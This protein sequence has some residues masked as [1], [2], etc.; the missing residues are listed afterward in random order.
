MLKKAC[1]PHPPTPALLHPPCPELAK[2][3]SLPE[4]CLARASV[5]AT[6]LL[7]PGLSMGKELV[8]ASSGPEDGTS[9]RAGAREGGSKG[10]IVVR[11]GR[12]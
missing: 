10:E 9:R 1:L 5:S 3:S 7:G 4:T 8:S 11:G 2:T 12:V 6:V